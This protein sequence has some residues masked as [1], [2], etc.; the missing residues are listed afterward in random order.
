MIAQRCWCGFLVRTEAL[1]LQRAWF[2]ADVPV[3]LPDET[4][5]IEYVGLL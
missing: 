1:K 4:E 3:G 2:E 5:M